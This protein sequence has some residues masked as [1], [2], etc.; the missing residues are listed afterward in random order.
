MMQQ[1]YY[2]RCIPSSSADR[3]KN[4]I[5]IVLDNSLNNIAIA[6]GDYSYAEANAFDNDLYQNVYDNEVE[7]ER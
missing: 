1:A 2:T 5:I 3:K 7:S 4:Y 6:K